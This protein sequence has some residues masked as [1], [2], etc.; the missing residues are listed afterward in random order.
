MKNM[1]KWLIVFICILALVITGCGKNDDKDDAKKEDDKSNVADK[2]KNEEDISS[3]K[4]EVMICTRTAKQSET[5]LDFKY[6]VTY[7]DGYVKRVL[8][9]EKITSSDKNLLQT[10]KNSVEELYEPYNSL[11]YYDTK[12]T[13]DGNTLTSIA[14]I[15]YE[16]IDTDKLIEIDSA[17]ASFI[18][19][20]KIK[21]EDIKAVYT[22][23]GAICDK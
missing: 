23:Y 21:L 1:K 8:S 16:K 14:E 2:D 17:N 7:S 5:N 10:Y 13:I 11:D 18:K 12:V 22:Q 19:D 9:T 3:T 15:D 6:Q 4:E 20:G